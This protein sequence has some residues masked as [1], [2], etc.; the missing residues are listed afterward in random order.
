MTNIRLKSFAKEWGKK[1]LKFTFREWKKQNEIFTNTWT[2][3]NNYY[4]N[5]ILKESFDYFAKEMR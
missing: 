4:Q 1:V 3:I 2:K 5:K